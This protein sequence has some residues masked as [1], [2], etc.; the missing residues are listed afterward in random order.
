VNTNQKIIAI[1]PARMASSRFPGKPL[2]PIMGIPMLGHVFFRS[3]MNTLLDEVYIATC[4][5]EIQ[6]YIEKI[7]GSAIMTADT[8][9]RASDRSAEA[10]ETIEKRLGEKVDIVVMIQGDEPMLRPEM[11][12][13]AVEPMLEN[14]AIQLVNLM[15]SLATIEEHD[16]V[17]EVKVVVDRNNDA[18]YFSREAIPSRW[19]LGLNA[20]RNKQVCIIPFRRD[21]LHKYNQLEPTP[22]EIAESVDMLRALEHGYK[23]RMV[24]TKFDIF[25][26]DTEEDR[27]RVENLMHD[28]PLIPL[29][30]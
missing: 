4:D 12:D 9:E 8:H 10:L 7:G 23:V 21:F 11:I 20:T 15:S 24:P 17:N 25:S 18:L 6:D 30:S 16:S 14:P 27:L 1:I 5:T 3:K 2:A 26:V 13:E 22:L 19:K 28:D 29:Y